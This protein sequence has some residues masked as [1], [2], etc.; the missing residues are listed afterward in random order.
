[1]E[2]E[3][4]LKQRQIGKQLFL[5]QMLHCE[6]DWVRDGGF[7]FLSRDKLA[8]WAD[9]S[10]EELDHFIAVCALLDPYSIATEAAKDF[11]YYGDEDVKKE[12]NAHWFV[13]S[14]YF[15]LAGMLIERINPNELPVICMGLAE[16]NYKRYCEK[17][18]EYPVDSSF[19]TPAMLERI[20]EFYLRYF[21]TCLKQVISEDFNWDVIA[22]M[23]G[24]EISEERFHMIEDSIKEKLESEKLSAVI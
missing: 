4:I 21:V 8:T 3:E 7:S 11:A 18:A 16:S 6:N 17:H 1:M 9:M 15:R 10:K 20:M 5:I 2:R 19:G 12:R 22:K 24:R 23:T 14:V 13:L